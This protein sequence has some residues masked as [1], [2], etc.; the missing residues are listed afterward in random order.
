MNT[1]ELIQ[2]VKALSDAFAQIGDT[3]KKV[4][5]AFR[6]ILQASQ[7]EKKRGLTTPKQ[8]G[9]QQVKRLY[10]CRES[11]NSYGY[12]PQVRRNLPYQRR[13]F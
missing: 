8:Y 3:M 11:I 5:D 6:E 13:N 9:M 10:K 2:A 4:A 7:K 12:I 1:E